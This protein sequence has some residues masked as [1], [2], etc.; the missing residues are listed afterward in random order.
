[1]AVIGAMIVVPVALAGMIAGVD[2]PWSSRGVRIEPRWVSLPPVRATTSD[3]TVVRTRVAADVSDS[4][5]KSALEREPQQVGL[6]LE[7]AIGAHSR[8]EI[9]ADG[10]MA[11]LSDAM[12][13]R[14]NGYL[15]RDDGKGE[16][17][18]SVVVQ[19][20]LFSKP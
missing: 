15:R 14:L 20:L 16:G 6:L 13:V 11:L 17:V 3:G 4:L 19:D 12:R 2:F 10:G 1:M 9:A 8:A 18:R 7:G 5:A